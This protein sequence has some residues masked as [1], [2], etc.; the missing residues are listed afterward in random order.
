MSTDTDNELV[1]GKCTEWT[2]SRVAHRDPYKKVG[3]C[4][5]PKPAWVTQTIS[6]LID[7]YD[8]RAEVCTCFRRKTFG[9]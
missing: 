2:R 7:Y 1:C 8:A 5:A 3:Q 4:T 6:P 9:S